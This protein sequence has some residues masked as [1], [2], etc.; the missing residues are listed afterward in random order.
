MQNHGIL[1]IGERAL[2]A[3]A[4][5]GFVASA[6]AAEHTWRDFDGVSN[7]SFIESNGDRAIQLSIEIAAPPTD[8]FAAFASSE[9]YS[10]WAVPVARVEFHVGGFIE[11]SYD[12]RARIGDPHNIRNEIL[13]Y[14]PERLLVIRNVQAPPEFTNAELFQRTVTVLEFAP[15]G[16]SHTRVTLTNPGYGSGEAFER[17]YRSLEWGDAYTLA[18]LRTRFD[19]GPVD[20]AA[21][22]AVRRAAEAA[23]T[24][25][26][27]P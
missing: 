15:A 25:E 12:P 8:V 21:R 26:S 3:A 24:V 23:R 19:K 17:I 6:I 9:A 22:E 4:A 2:L 11:S 13:A 1:G 20:W 14:V 5:F 16:Q 18:E 7:S 10:S 27:R